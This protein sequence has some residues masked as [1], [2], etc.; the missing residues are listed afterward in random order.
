MSTQVF[1]VR[2]NALNLDGDLN[3]DGTDD[4]DD[5]AQGIVIQKNKVKVNGSTIEYNSNDK[6]S[7]IINGTKMPK[8]A[9]DKIMDSMKNN[10]KRMENVNISIKDGKKEISIKTE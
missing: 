1:K 3:G 10:F 5:D 4:D 2:E 6:D 7:V 8:A 9:A